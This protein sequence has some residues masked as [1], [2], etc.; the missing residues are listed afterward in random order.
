M[1]HRKRGPRKSPC[2]GLTGYRELLIFSTESGDCELGLETREEWE[3]LRMPAFHPRH[4]PCQISA[5]GVT[6]VLE[7]T[8]PKKDSPRLKE[9]HSSLFIGRL[10][11]NP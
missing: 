1:L 11:D 10:I 6:W 7:Q 9:S 2:A 4:R 5:T 3:T 8:S